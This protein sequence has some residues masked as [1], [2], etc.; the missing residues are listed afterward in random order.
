MKMV[1]GK[2]GRLLTRVNDELDEVERK[3]QGESKRQ[4]KPGNG[5]GR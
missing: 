4:W 3:G 1:L 5:N 2:A